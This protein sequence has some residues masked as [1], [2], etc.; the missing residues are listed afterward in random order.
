MFREQAVVDHYHLRPP[1]PEESVRLLAQIASGGAVVDLGCGTGELARRLASTARVDAVDVSAPMV[2]RGRLLPG[3]ESASLRW[4]IGRV[5]DVELDG[6]YA[7]AVAGDS[8]HWF[9]WGTLFP[10]LV[11]LVP[12]G[13]LAL[14]HREWL[15]DEQLWASLNPVYDRHSWNEEFEPHDLVAELERRSLFVESGRSESEP[16]PWRPTLEELVAVHFSASGF[17]PSKLTDRERFAAEVR[18]AVESTL[19]PRDD[20][21]DLD[22]VATV[23][24]GRP[25]AG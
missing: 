20:R 1:Y 18:A 3:G 2:E 25:G 17:A 22:V 23:T 7:L 21:Y 16:V 5:E 10:R 9:D 8:M 19:E 15:R 4:H 6:P 12:D 11:E 13:M 24:W 14:V